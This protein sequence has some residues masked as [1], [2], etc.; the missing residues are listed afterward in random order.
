MDEKIGELQRKERTLVALENDGNGTVTELFR[1]MSKTGNH[2]IAFYKRSERNRLF[3]RLA[4][5]NRSLFNIKSTRGTEYL[6]ISEPSDFL[7]IGTCGDMRE[8]QP[9]H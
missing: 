9:P 3:Q 2:E 1:M 6:P 8:G 5:G 7:R 4:R